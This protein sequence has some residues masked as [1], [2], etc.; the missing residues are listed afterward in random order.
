MAS[1]MMTA[2]E[3]LQT[4]TAYIIRMLRKQGIAMALIAV[5]ISVV[6]SVGMVSRSL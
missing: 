3:A 1:E 6:I 5:V 4:H 2:Q